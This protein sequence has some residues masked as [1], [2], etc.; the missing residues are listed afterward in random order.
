MRVLIFGSRGWHDAGPINAVIAGLDI[1]AEGR[2]E[3]LTIIR[4]P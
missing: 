1:L 3:R 4:R 2:G